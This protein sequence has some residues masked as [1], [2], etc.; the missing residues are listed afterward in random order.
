M[1]TIV[2]NHN[3]P[4]IVVEQSVKD[5]EPY[6]SIEIRL[7]PQVMSSLWYFHK[8]LH[9][10][11]HFNAG[12]L[13]HSECNCYDPELFLKIIRD[14]VN[15]VLEYQAEHVRGVFDEWLATSMLFNGKV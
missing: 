3:V 9:C 10:K 1:F 6:T 11:R 14:E 13:V 15:A 8:V 12:L 2:P 4:S 5:G 7:G